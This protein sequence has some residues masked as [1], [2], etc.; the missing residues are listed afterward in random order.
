MILEGSYWQESRGDENTTDFTAAVPESFGIQIETIKDINELID[1]YHAAAKRY[2]F[3]PEVD[4]L[5]KENIV[6]FWFPEH[7]M[8]ALR[9]PRSSW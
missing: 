2:G 5:P 6:N 3:D 9:V 8:S 7:G 4:A 1:I